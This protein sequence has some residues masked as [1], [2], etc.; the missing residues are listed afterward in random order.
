MTG[1][2]PGFSKAWL[3]AGPSTATPS[4]KSQVAFRSAA[5]SAT[6]QA[7]GTPGQSG[8]GAVRPASGGGVTST[9]RTASTRLLPTPASSVTA[10]RTR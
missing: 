4:P 8:G 9:V 5:S 10:S 7:C 6:L 3:V 2:T 1:K